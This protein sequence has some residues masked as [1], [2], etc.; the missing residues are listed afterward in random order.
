MQREFSRQRDHLEHTLSGVRRKLA[1]DAEIHKAEY[2][3][4]MHVGYTD[5]TLKMT[6]S[7]YGNAF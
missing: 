4:I 3:H 2:V 6:H 5:S 7:Q 1:K